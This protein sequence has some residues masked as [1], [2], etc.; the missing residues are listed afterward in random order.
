LSPSNN[1]KFFRTNPHLHKFEDFVHGVVDMGFVFPPSFNNVQGWSQANPQVEWLKWG[2][3]FVGR[4]ERLEEDWVSLCDLLGLP[5]MKLIKENINRSGSSGY[6]QFY[7]DRLVDLVGKYYK[8][9]IERW[10]YSF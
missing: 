10:G 3:D 6:R 7:D 8:E 1:K 5:R 9:D 4:F 2:V